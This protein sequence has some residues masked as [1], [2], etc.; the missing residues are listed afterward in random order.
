MSTP[1]CYNCKLAEGE[2]PHPSNYRGCGHA[3]RKRSAE[4]DPRKKRRQK[5]E[6]SSYTTSGMAIVAALCKKSEKSQQPRSDQIAVP[7]ETTVV[8]GNS[9]TASQ[10]KEAGQSVQASN[11]NSDLLDM[12]RAL[13][14]V[15]QIVAEL[16]CIFKE[17]KFL[18]L[19]RIVCNLMTE[20][21]K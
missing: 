3:K 5:Q 17:A 9:S 1:S 16:K 8:Q 15:E 14:V 7:A 18:A 20:N 11:V 6:G 21:D 19:A 4:G 13:T 2:K 12:V 10:Q